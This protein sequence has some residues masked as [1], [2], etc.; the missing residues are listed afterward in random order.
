MNEAY[1][2]TSATDAQTPYTQKGL[3]FTRRFFKRRRFAL[4]RSAMGEAHG[5]HY[6]HQGKHDL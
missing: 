5:I 1:L 2:Q 6:R 3:T 4:R